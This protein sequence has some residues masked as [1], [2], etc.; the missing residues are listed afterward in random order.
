MPTNT[1]YYQYQTVNHKQQMNN[2]FNAERWK[3]S[4][5]KS[6]LQ[7]DVSGYSDAHL[8]RVVKYFGFGDKF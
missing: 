7:K 5:C 3:G 6:K 8:I 4:C 1:N 2:V